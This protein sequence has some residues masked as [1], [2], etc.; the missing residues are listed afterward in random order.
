LAVDRSGRILTTP[1]FNRFTGGLAL[2]AHV[3]DAA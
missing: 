1:G 3:E 2:A